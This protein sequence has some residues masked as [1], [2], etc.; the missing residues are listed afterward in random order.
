[1]AMNRNRDRS[2][3]DQPASNRGVTRWMRRALIALGVGLAGVIV[4]LAWPW[5]REIDLDELARHVEGWNGAVVFA[6]MVVLPVI[7]FPVTPL[8]AIAGARFG[9]GPGVILAACSVGLNL[10]L[11]YWITTSSLRNPIDRLIR[12][13]TRFQLPR[14][15]DAEQVTVTLF[16][17]LLPAISYALKNYLMALSQIR[18]WIYIGIG[19]LVHTSKGSL[20][21]LAGDLTDE[22]TPVKIALLA[23]YA[24][25][26]TALCHHIVTRLRK[27]GIAKIFVADENTES[28]QPGR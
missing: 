16:V 11:V 12:R 27:R 22:M 23:L 6:L 14:I 24:I 17:T 5:I 3:T 15:P 26:L 13:R 8:F 10:I 19:S 9:T 4:I 21:I 18:F 20:A 7:G 28:D 1:M 2:G 25:V